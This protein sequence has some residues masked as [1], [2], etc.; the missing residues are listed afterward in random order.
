M[1]AREL[2]LTLEE[3]DRGMY[4]T[5]CAKVDGSLFSP[6]NFE[7]LFFILELDGLY[8]LAGTRRSDGIGRLFGVAV[9]HVC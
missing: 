9:G 2:E 7:P 5:N 6:E 1:T 8:T 3:D 4:P